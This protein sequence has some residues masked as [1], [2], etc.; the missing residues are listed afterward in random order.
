MNDIIFLVSSYFCDIKNLINMNNINLHSYNNIFIE[1]LVYQPLYSNKIT[2]NTLYQKKFV[3]LKKLDLSENQCNNINLLHLENLQ[4]LILGKKENICPN[5]FVN[6]K[7]LYMN[8]SNIFI[9]ENLITEK[10]LLLDDSAMHL[11]S[12]QI[13]S[14]MNVYQKK[15][16]NF[17]FMG[18]FPIDFNE[19]PLLNFYKDFSK[20]NDPEYWYIFSTLIPIICKVLIGYPYIVT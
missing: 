12:L 17:I 6:I 20:L 7:I 9:D 5:N 15:Y 8:T 19:V 1:N 13:D 14:L 16:P 11:N 4:E 3:K 18:N 2:R 10:V